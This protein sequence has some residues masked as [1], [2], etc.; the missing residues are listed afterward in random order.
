MS[1][2]DMISDEE[3]MAMIG[4]PEPVGLTKMQAAA[5]ELY[6]ALGHL[7]KTLSSIGVELD[8]ISA[9]IT[10]IDLLNTEEAEGVVSSAR[11]AIAKAR[12]E[13]L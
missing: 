5:P 13:P 11:A 6:E 3:I 2:L 1:S 12:G 10:L 9:P 4:K 7:L 8:C